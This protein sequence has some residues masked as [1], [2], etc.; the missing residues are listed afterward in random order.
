MPSTHPPAAQA[1][2]TSSAAPARRRRTSS[3]TC[4][5]RRPLRR[6][7]RGA[8]R[9]G[10]ALRGEGQPRPG[11]SRELA[12]VGCRFDVAS[13]AEV[14]AVIS[15]GVDARPTSSTPTRSSAAT[16]SS[17]PR[18]LGVRLFVVDSMPRGPQGRRS[19]PGQC[20]PVPPGHLRRRLGLAALRA[21]TAARSRRRVE[22][23]TRA[24]V[25]RPRSRRGLLPR[26]LTATRPG[27]RGASRSTPRHAC[28][29]CCDAEA[30]GPRLLDMGGGFP[31]GCTTS[32]S[33]STRGVRRGHRGP[34][35]PAPSAT[36]SPRRSSSPAAASSATP[37]LSC[38]RSSA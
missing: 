35:P 12:A 36:R 32:A 17:R 21:S 6:A 5:R 29:N 30:C 34:P 4:R 3:W 23:L 27:G 33:P 13:P 1:A 15:A 31:A 11:C 9:D 8:F 37:G 38:P 2:A 24:G 28:S 25:P 16:T 14:R 22:V 26:G 18:D 7:D 20:R 10:G 19:R